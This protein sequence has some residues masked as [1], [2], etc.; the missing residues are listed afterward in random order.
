MHQVHDHDHDGHSHQH[1]VIHADF[2]SVSAQ[3]HRHARQ[4]AAVLGADSPWAF[5][6]SGLIGLFTRNFDSQLTIFKK[7]PDV[8][9]IGVAITHTQL[10]LFAHI[11]KRDHSPPLQPVSLAPNAPRSPPHFV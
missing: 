2:L 8:F 11:L 4:E 5:S 7:S 9:L 10:I 6:Q 3:D 1:A